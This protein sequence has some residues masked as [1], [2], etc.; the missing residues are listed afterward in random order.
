MLKHRARVI[1]LAHV[2]PI[3]ALTLGLQGDDADRDERAR[4]S[5]LRRVFAGRRAARRHAGAV[6]RDAVRGDVRLSRSGCGRRIRISR[7]AVSRTMAKSR[8]AWACPAIPVSA[9]TIALAT[10]FA[11]VRETGVRV[12]LCRLSTAGGVE[13]VRAAKAEGL[14]RYLRCR[15]A[16]PALVRCRHRLVRPAGEPGAAAAQHARPRCVTRRRR[17]RHGRRD[18]FRPRAGRRRWQAG[19]IRGS[20]AGRDRPGTAAAVVAQMGSAKSDCP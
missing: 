1:N 7:E 12:H 16:S 17:R 20:R 15:R 13:M 18:L 19:A 11:L 10:I 14:P 8:R 2:Y 6:P 5:R 9:E 4:R 3:G